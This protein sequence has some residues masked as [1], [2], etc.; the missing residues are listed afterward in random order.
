MATSSGA[1]SA[2]S[3]AAGSSGI[4]PAISADSSATG[5]PSASASAATSGHPRRDLFGHCFRHVFCRCVLGHDRFAIHRRVGARGFGMLIPKFP[6]LNASSMS[7]SSCDLRTSILG[8]SK[9]RPEI[10]GRKNENRPKAALL[11]VDQFRFTKMITVQR[12]LRYPL[13]QLRVDCGRSTLERGTQP[14]PCLRAVHQGIGRG[15]ML[16]DCGPIV[17][18]AQKSAIPSANVDQ[19]LGSMR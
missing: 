18:S 17:G 15:L 1:C 9:E 2:T 13:R 11:L 6:E 3:S 8:I 5:S 14:P 12:G 19:F 10:P 16:A 7:S 4:S